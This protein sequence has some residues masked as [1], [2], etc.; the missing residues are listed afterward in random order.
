MHMIQYNFSETADEVSK[1]KTFKSE[2]QK[3]YKDF[4]EKEQLKKREEYQM[5]MIPDDD[6]R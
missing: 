3:K 2:F 5:L 1:K 4:V 6:Y